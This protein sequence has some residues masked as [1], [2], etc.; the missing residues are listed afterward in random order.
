M[1]YEKPEALEVGSAQ[2]VVL[3]AK[4][5]SGSEEAGGFRIVNPLTEVDE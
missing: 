5:M 1:T 4:G 2:D 3:G